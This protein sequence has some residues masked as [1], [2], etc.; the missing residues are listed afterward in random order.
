MSSRL[1]Q[2]L[3]SLPPASLGVLGSIVAIFIAQIVL[4]FNVRQF[5]LCPADVI[6]HGQVWRLLTSIGLHGS[7]LH[8]GMNVMSGMGLCSTLERTLGTV[9]LLLTTLLSAATSPIIHI[10]IAT[11]ARLFFGYNVWFQEHSLGFSGILFH[12]A[13]IDASFNSRQARSVFGMFTVSNMWYP[14]VLMVVLQ[15]FMPHLS[16]L[17][18]LSGILAGTV[19]VQ[20][21]IRCQSTWLEECMAGWHNFVPADH[22]IMISSGS[23]S[24]TS[25]RQAATIVCVYAGYILE[26]IRVVVWGRRAEEDSTVL[27]MSEYDDDW[28]GL[29]LSE[30]SVDVVQAQIV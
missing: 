25:V 3:Q 27:I 18:H 14:W 28:I 22:T 6:V 10:V 7:A 24:R 19:Q 15:L 23:D 21:N 17:G 12:Y 26:T 13:V 5:T 1:H 11:T 30:D 4:D 2:L 8:L 20:W 9:A 29:P 16:F